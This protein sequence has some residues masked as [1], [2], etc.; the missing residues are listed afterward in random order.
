M[1]AFNKTRNDGVQKP[2]TPSSYEQHVLFGL[3][4]YTPAIFGSPLPPVAL[5]PFEMHGPCY[6][7]NNQFSYEHLRR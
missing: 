6:S 3:E 2:Q 4:S 5:T 7:Y 1:S